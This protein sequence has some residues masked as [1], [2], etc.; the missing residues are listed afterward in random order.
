[1]TTP[2][3]A[4]PSHIEGAVMRRFLLPA[5]GIAAVLFV[6]GAIYWSPP[7]NQ[8]KAYGNLPMHFEPSADAQ[9]YATRGAG[10]TLQLGANGAEV[11]LA[12]GQRSAALALHLEGATPRPARPENRLPG[13][14]NYFLG[15]D[16]RAWRTGVPHYA[17]VR[18][19]EVY[20][21]VDLVYYGRQ[22]E[23]EYDFIVAP[24]GDPARIQM[25][26]AGAR[27]VSIDSSGN[28]RI[29]VAGGEVIQRKPVSYQ[30]VDGVRRMVDSAFHVVQVAGRAIVGF[31]LGDYDARRALT[32]DPVLSYATYLGGVDDND[33]ATTLAVD[34]TGA[35][36]VAGQTNSIDFPVTP[37]VVQPTHTG[38]GQFDAF[39]AKLNPAGTA[40]EYVTYL[41]GSQMEESMALRVDA[42]GNA[43]LAGQTSST[44]FPVTAGAAQIASGGSQDVFIAKLNPTG[45]ALLY[46]TYLG[47]TGGEPES[48]RLGGMAVAPSGDLYVYGDTSSADFPTT[49]GAPQTT[50]GNPNTL[51]FDEDVFLTRINANGTA[52]TFSTYLG[53]SGFE[54][55]G[56]PVQENS[57]LIIDGTGS[58]WVAGRTESANFPASA[59][60]FDTSFGGIADGFVARFDTNTS[61]LLYS[62][63]IGGNGEDAGRSLD[64]DAGGNAYVLLQTFSSNFPTS[65]GAPDTTY[66][67]AGDVGLVK[68]NAAGSALLYGTYLGDG[69]ADNPQVLRVDAAG[70]AYIA[71]ETRSTTIATPGAADT[72]FNGGLWDGFIARLNAAGTAFDYVTYA[73]SSDDDPLFFMEIDAAGSA[74]AVLGDTVGDAFLTPGAR[75]YSGGWDDYFVKVN[76]AGTVFLDAAYLG[77]TDDDFSLAMTIDAQE[78]VYLAGISNSTN[79]PVTAGA[80]QPVKAGPANAEDSFLVKLSTT[81]A[82]P[83]AQP[84]NLSLSGASFSV[85]ENAGSISI[86]VTRSGGTDGAVSATCSAAAGGGDTAT[87]GIDFTATNVTLNWADG[88]SANKTCNVPI[89]NDAAVENAETFTVTLSNATGGAS[90]GSP[91]TATVTINDD[92]VAPVPQPG[93]VGFDPASYSLDETGGSVT[94]TLTRTA[95]ADGAISVNVA[96]GGGS[97]SSGADY[98]AMNQTVNWADGDSASKSVLLTVL[99]DSSDEPNETVSVSL[100]NTTG[101]ATLGVANA[102]LTIVDDDV[103][104]PPQPPTQQQ[105]QA[106]ARYGG[107][108]DGV[109]LAM[110]FGLVGVTLYGRHR[111][112]RRRHDDLK[113]HAGLACLLLA[114]FAP[115]ARGSDGWYLGVRGGVGESTQQAS[116]IEAALGALGHDVDVQVKDNEPTYTLFGGHRWSNGLALEGSLFDLGEYEVDIDAT[117]SSPGALL[118]DTEA[119][120]GDSGR[121]V[122]AA[123][124]WT[125]RVGERVEIT[126]RLGAY[127]W[128]SRRTVESDAGRLTNRQFGVDLMGGVSV[129]LIVDDHWSLGLDW[130]S[131]AANGHNDIRTITASLSYRFGR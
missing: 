77:G 107:S 46:S 47:G 112:R 34:G 103:T 98:T 79:Y 23:L 119:V 18:Y 106:R 124:A 73:G 96:S 29:E 129:D 54:E 44:N 85:A 100:S 15:D 42:A 125:W 36:Y 76:P 24:G 115:G 101:G 87:A 27:A 86:A 84:G 105:T 65:A 38:F 118:A 71:G 1:V 94:L 62:T 82:S 51:Q 52:F 56:D 45:T 7:A 99:D 104:T 60:A 66:A 10:F 41:G 75:P 16:P 11:H 110:L 116:D 58:A 22:G 57:L 67:G 78:N 72:T 97:A 69:L 28:L 108:L 89:G 109:L 102:T 26:Y 43:Y 111:A 80:P 81:P 19:E 61:S 63:C 37:G 64:T 12:R 117:T 120:L 30:L 33:D 91:V 6:M 48:D 131:W 128:E 123:L 25:S 130:Q 2:P 90:L 74:Y 3:K 17:R 40:Y 92:D 4:H 8:S 35:L 39:V 68:I 50:R 93:T 9:V 113:L 32:I 59:G 121:G 53:G 5:A 55:V 13:V 14:S 20:P 126:P 127:Y 88:D 95:G 122:G 83:A 21:R 70:R 49:P 31:E 114:A